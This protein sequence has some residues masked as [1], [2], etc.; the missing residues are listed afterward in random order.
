MKENK[1]IASVVVFKELLDSNKDIYDII[2]EFIK[3]AVIDKK[4]WSFNSTEL[5][6]LLEEVFDFKMPE[7]VIRTTLKN[8]LIREGFLTL[9][10]GIYSVVDIETKINP[11]FE[12]SFEDKRKLYKKTEDEFIAYIKNSKGKDLSE[13]EI[14]KIRSNINHYLLG[15]GINEPYNQEISAFIIKKKNDREFAERLNVVKEGVVLY[16]G[17]R[18]T[19]DL[20]EL[21]KW[22]KPLVIFLDTDIIF[23][24]LGYNGKVYKEI[25][26]DF[27]KLV[28]EINQNNGKRIVQLKYF[29]ETKNEIIKFFHVASLIIEG[30]MRLDPTKTAM[31][32]IINDCK[33]KSD[34]I[35]KR[36]KFFIDLKTSGIQLEE[37]KDYYENSEFNIE[38]LDVIEELSKISREK[39]RNF[40]EES[41]K[42]SLKLF[43]KINVL[44]KGVSNQGF[45]N[46]KYIL[47][48][49]SGYIHY[50]AHNSQI[51]VN[52]KDIPFA[53]D[54][55]YITDKFWFKLKKGFGSSEDVPKS[56]DIITKAQI[57]LASQM[58]NTV[59]EKYT[60]L[61]EKYQ[62]GKITKEEVIS[63]TYD[64]R[65]S[66]LK[67]EE[68]EENN[69][70][71]SITFINDF[72][73]EDHIKAKE[74]LNLKVLEGEAAKKE[75]K[76]R[77]MASRTKK[78]K[79][80]KL[81]FKAVKVLLT[82]LSIAVVL[83]LY[84]LGY[85][86]IEQLREPG[87]S[88]LSVIGFCLGIIVLIPIQK[89]WNRYDR[90]VRKQIVK[91][92]KVKIAN[93][94]SK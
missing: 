67:P 73:L 76:R 30:K 61:N 75:L 19:A 6:F 40:D 54:L 48:T 58:N 25:F 92:Y 71:D 22:K 29:E 60:A 5:R 34:V 13:V 69:V 8:R 51:K 85:Y 15:N 62:E 44:R 31:K 82:I 53:T 49:G 20:N 56:F 91:K 26:M 55:D 59:H 1:L 38:G 28:R 72:S 9:K 89:L 57:V 7:A 14:L 33:S 2:S 16:A 88:K 63:L 93:F 83:F 23:N 74:L 94:F 68:I 21:G 45:E 84:Y 46:C 17:V 11:L 3:A 41:C 52:E 66:T 4:K 37:N 10:K 18:Y 12:S 24:Y 78:I 43:T 87:D 64:L 80:L 27:I 47:L 90:M 79:K 65:E 35:V 50:L 36:N 81:F 32:E 70:D 39:R 77:D 86:V 42:N